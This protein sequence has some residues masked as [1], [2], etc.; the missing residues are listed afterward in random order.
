MSTSDVG[1][2]LFSLA[3][4]SIGG[5]AFAPGILTRLGIRRG[6]SWGLLSLGA[7]LGVLGLVTE[8]LGSTVGA[9]AVL[10]IYGF[11]F[12]ATDVMMNV[13]GAAVERALGKT[14]LPLMH[15]FF[16]FGTII[17]AVMGAGAASYQIDVLWNFTIVGVLIMALGIYFARN[18]SGLEPPATE[19]LEPDLPADSWWK[20][21]SGIFHDG[22]L[23]LIGL[24]VAGLAFAE[25]TANDWLTIASVDDHGFSEANGAL[26]FGAFV[27]AMTIGRI[28]GGPLIDRMG[29]KRVLVAMGLLGLAGIALFILAQAPW[30][31][32]A[33]AVL[34]GLGGSLGFPVG[35]SV[36]AAHPTDGPR[37]VGIVAVFGYSSMLVGPPVLG[38]LGEHF[39]VLRAFILVAAVL[40]LTLLITPKATGGQTK[41]SLPERID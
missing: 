25:G 20:R 22:H 29:H 37:R 34:W 1:I 10:V 18:V 3:I 13:D 2:L 33:G 9:M 36:A 7:V 11:V 27:A 12:S 17:G 28:F 38:F 5:L 19:G 4:G 35:M 6:I 15:A 31:V 24:M 14:V 23:M 21:F 30:A 40:L 39:G 8:L 16:S 41:R 32:F 26:V